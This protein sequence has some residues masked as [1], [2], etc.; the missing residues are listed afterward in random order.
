MNRT[1]RS[2]VMGGLALGAAGMAVAREADGRTEPVSIPLGIETMEGVVAHDGLIRLPQIQRQH[3]P[4]YIVIEAEDAQVIRF[5]QR[6][7]QDDEL[8]RGM[9][10]EAS[11]GRFVAHMQE[12]V[13]EF[14]ITTP[15][16]Y[17]VMSRVWAPWHGSWNRTE[18]MNAWEQDLHVHSADA[19]SKRSVML[20]GDTLG[21]TGAAESVNVVDLLV[22]DPNSPL[23]K[24]WIWVKPYDRRTGKPHVYRLEAGRNQLKFNYQ[25]G[26]RLDKLILARNHEELPTGIG[27]AAGRGLGPESG[28]VVTTD[29]QPYRVKRW[30]GLRGTLEPL[31]GAIRRAY[32]LDRGATWTE[33]ADDDELA[34][35][36][37]KGDGSDTIRFRLDLERGANH[38]TP[39]LQGLEL[40][41]VSGGED[42]QPA[43]LETLPADVVTAL[44]R[45]DLS[46]IRM[47]GC[48]AEDGGI[49]LS[50]KLFVM[51]DGEAL[52]IDAQDFA[53]A[54]FDPNRQTA[55]RADP[56]ASGGLVVYQYPHCRN[57][58]RYDFAVPRA[59]DYRFYY[60]I[61]FDQVGSWTKMSFI[62]LNHGTLVRDAIE[63][64]GNYR[65]EHGWILAPGPTFRNL[66]EGSHSFHLRGRLDY[67]HID[68]LILVPADKTPAE[69]GLEGV[70]PFPAATPQPQD[71]GVVHMAAV[72]LPGVRRWQ[73]VE[74]D[75]ERH[76]GQVLG[77]VSQDDDRWLNIARLP[78]LDAGGDQDGLSVR[79]ALRRGPDG[80]SP[81]LRKAWL[82]ADAPEARSLVLRNE[83]TEARWS[84]NGYLTGLLDRRND[85]WIVPL[86]S[87]LPLV[88]LS[89]QVAGETS[90]RGIRQGDG[91]RLLERAY[92]DGEEGRSLAFT[93]G[94]MDNAIRLTC[95]FT[96]RNDDS[97]V[98]LKV[99]VVNESPVIIR[100][101]TPVVFRDI[102][103]GAC[104]LNETFAWPHHIGQLHS[105]PG[106]GMDTVRDIRY[107]GNACMAWLDVSDP[108][109]GFYI[110]SLDEEI[111][112][113][114]LVYD[115][116]VR[117][118]GWNFKGILHKYL[119]PRSAWS[120][121]FEFGPHPGGWHWGADRYHD[122][123]YARHGRP[124]YPEWVKMSHGWWNAHGSQKLYARFA[125]HWYPRAQYLGFRHYQ[126]WGTTACGESCGF[127]HLYNPRFG[128]SEQ[129]LEANREL[130]ALGCQ[131]G[132]YLNVQGWSDEYARDPEFLGATP[133]KF[134]PPE[135]LEL[136]PPVGWADA[137]AVMPLSGNIIRGGPGLLSIPGHLQRNMCLADTGPGG[138]LEHQ[139]FWLADMGARRHEVGCSYIDQTSCIRMPLCF[140]EAHGH[141]PDHAAAGR[142]LTQMLKETVLEGRRHN[143]DYVLGVEGIVDVHAQWAPMGLYVGSEQNKGNLYLYTHPWHFY[144]RGTSNGGGWDPIP[145][146]SHV[147]YLTFLH[148]RFDFGH[149]ESE[150]LRDT[151]FVREQVKDWLYNA[152]FMDGI[153]LSVDKGGVLAK[154]FRRDD[155][156]HRGAV[157]N[158]CNIERVAG[159]RATLTGSGLGDIRYALAYRKDRRLEILPVTVAGDSLSFELP[160][161]EVASILLIATCPDRERL[162]VTADQPLRAG[163]GALVVALANLS[164]AP[165]PVTVAIATEPELA[166]AANPFEIVVPANS[167][168]EKALAVHGL[169]EQPVRS[170][171][172][173]TA[174]APAGIVHA[175][176]LLMPALLNGDFEIE[177]DG[178]ADVWQTF[179]A[180]VS[181]G[182]KD[183]ALDT[184]APLT[185]LDGTV[186]RTVARSGE[187]S[188]RLD[189][190][191]R[192]A[193]RR[194]PHSPH[195]HLRDREWFDWTH[196][197]SQSVILKPDTEYEISF[198]YRVE[199]Q[200]GEM[201]AMLLDVNTP[202]HFRPIWKKFPY[203]DAE[204]GVWH[205][206]RQTLPPTRHRGVHRLTFTN[207]GDGALW[208][209]NVRLREV[210][211]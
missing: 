15:G 13:F 53:A 71:F 7:F 55:L 8:L 156:E 211:P 203:A 96:L 110:A 17:I 32:S 172:R 153:G 150:N 97:L 148:N 141:G 131:W 103:L 165:R 36:P 114:D 61:R 23:L 182:L 45:L 117:A 191:S 127:V 25:G 69:L 12:I 118:G 67:S 126:D 186:D 48:I 49:R 90:L 6:I 2:V 27:P 197:V 51:R 58:I 34:G 57:Q 38:A 149:T 210:R 151:I 178:T 122:W 144:Y 112:L 163:E 18:T 140:N 102:H 177:R 104:G 60:R 176:A 105:D 121:A 10:P 115:P 169:Q 98:N 129:L 47:E 35:V 171:V 28:S 91:F 195:A 29:V 189:G 20:P 92:S 37:V 180:A 190:R 26:I 79:V 89:Y 107:P 64:P 159:A 52:V 87:R 170:T 9:D 201:E 81:V 14:E 82:K 111:T 147:F 194:F 80:A 142:N 74:V 192:F 208:L 54:S 123:F 188:L 133:K 83:T 63:I 120:V 73:G 202:G 21:D 198:F 41:Y 173:V 24:Q 40:A 143:P 72:R 42:I 138:W 93:F 85:R 11:N 33:F 158:I 95:T 43:P 183:Y 187:A 206:V 101:L 132:G 31:G 166:L 135:F 1:I 94:A 3:H 59:G 157:V 109:G 66:P 119:P 162:R 62:S 160:E 128:S 139:K 167:V 113:L 46:P 16:D 108:R 106:V 56:E 124:E 19:E 78:E 70:G 4:D 86:G 134:F 125:T 199:G 50:D 161:T 75:A 181:H 179:S 76:G 175:E 154:W 193:H 184:P 174:S 44:D 116:G 77:K 209:D 30:L 168:H 68:Q 207:H 39:I 145:R 196:N 136:I 88:E 205:E 137:H 155:A 164:D 130:R 5:E 146:D 100:D 65:P 84:P 22:H 200:E 204:P 99:D 152:R 185:G